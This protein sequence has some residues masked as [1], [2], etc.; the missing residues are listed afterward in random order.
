M[1]GKGG[2]VYILT[3]KYHTTLYTGVC[4]DL[5]SRIKQHK[6]KF[7]PHSFTSKYNC[8]KLVYY[9]SFYSIEEAIAEEKRIKGGS[10]A[11]KIALIESNNPSWEDLWDV[12]SKW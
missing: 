4:S 12:I 5:Y 3:N 2:C 8:T 9:N 1:T 6:E 10:R 11:K 7:Y